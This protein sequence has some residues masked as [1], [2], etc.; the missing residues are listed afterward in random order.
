[1][2]KAKRRCRKAHQ[3]R[4]SFPHWFDG[5]TQQSAEW[6]AFNKWIDL[7]LGK[8]VDLDSFPY[9]AFNRQK[10]EDFLNNIEFDTSIQL[11]G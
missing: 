9:Q 3:E 10:V 8:E 7:C 1:M 4:K 5:P 6:L 11:N 2:A